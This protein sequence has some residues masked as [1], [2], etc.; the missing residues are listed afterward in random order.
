MT[1]DLS[2]QLTIIPSM[3]MAEA[4]Y[5]PIVCGSEIGCA[6]CSQPVKRKGAKFCSLNCFGRHKALPER[7][8]PK[9][10]GP[11]DK[12]RLNGTQ[13][14]KCYRQ[15][16]A[17]KPA[18]PCQN[19]GKLVHRGPAKWKQ[20]SRRYGAFCSRSCFGQFVTGSKN[21]AFI[22]GGSPAEYPKEFVRIRKTVLARDGGHCFLCWAGGKMDIHHIDRDRSNNALANLVTLCR[23]CHNHQKGSPLE[24]LKLANVLSVKLSVAYGYPMRCII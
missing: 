24:V 22:D 7:A 5:P 2:T 16:R 17:V 4:T 13:C 21:P 18:I 6:V 20:T 23:K 15:S 3:S 1:D 19:C 11:C 14:A 10:G 8:C 12:H 9:C